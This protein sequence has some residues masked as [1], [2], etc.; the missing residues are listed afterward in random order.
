MSALPEGQEDGGVGGKAGAVA[1]NA[2]F[3]TA[4]TATDDDD[5]NES[6]AEESDELAAMSRADAAL[7]A[8]ECEELELAFRLCLLEDDAALLK[9][10][11]G[12]VGTP[13]MHQ[14]SRASRSALCAAFL[15]ILDGGDRRAASSRG[16]SHHDKWLVFAWLRDLGTRRASVA[17]IDPRVLR[18]LGERLQEL[19]AA[20]ASSAGLEAANVLSLLDL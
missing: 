11:M 3:G 8:A 20:D 4:A 7:R 1:F 10:V 16:G 17:Q 12:V 2:P 15:E 14:L 5:N 19:S 9:Q 13:C 6:E 18:V